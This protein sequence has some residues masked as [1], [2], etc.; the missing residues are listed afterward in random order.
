MGQGTICADLM[1][2]VSRIITAPVLTVSDS[3]S[4][5]ILEPVAAHNCK[6]AKKV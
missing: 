2:D 4:L 3:D 1:M 5:P 6:S